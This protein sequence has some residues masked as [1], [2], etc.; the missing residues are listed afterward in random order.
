[1]KDCW[2]GFIIVAFFLFFIAFRLDRV[3]VRLSKVEA[4]C[5]TK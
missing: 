2:I 1:M 3:I 4:T 5:L